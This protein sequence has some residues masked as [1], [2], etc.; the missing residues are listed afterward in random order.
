MPLFESLQQQLSL[1]AELSPSL[2]RQEALKP[3]AAWIAERAKADAQADLIFVCTHNSRRSHIAQIW[4][5]AA[6]FFSGL[7]HVVTWSGG[8]EATAF[9]PRAVKAMSQQGVRLVETGRQISEGNIIYRATYGTDLREQ[10]LYSKLYSDPANPQEGFA[11]VMVCDSAD[12]ACPLVAGAELR[13][14]LPFVDPKRSDDTVEEEDVHTESAQEI[15]LVMA[16]LM[17]CAKTASVS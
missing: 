3:L 1:W 5:Q 17:R 14:S 13:V 4:A 16:W 15:G 8:T 2:D 6:A 9:N 11:A 7:S 12:E 10:E